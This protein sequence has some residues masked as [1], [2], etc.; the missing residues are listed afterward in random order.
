KAV[1]GQIRDAYGTRTDAAENL[2]SDLSN[3]AEQV[4]QFAEQG[5][6]LTGRTAPKV[7]SITGQLLQILV[8]FDGLTCDVNVMALG[9]KQRELIVEATRP[10]EYDP[11]LD[12]AV[13]QINELIAKLQELCNRHVHDLYDDTAAGADDTALAVPG[14]GET[15]EAGETPNVEERICRQRC[16]DLYHA[17]MRAED[18]YLRADQKAKDARAKVGSLPQDR[19]S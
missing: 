15:A 13:Q 18:A 5:G 8:N 16:G 3:L 19:K 2:I 17:F 14:G 1:T 4:G 10:G 6:K 11:E 7:A 9:I 12:R